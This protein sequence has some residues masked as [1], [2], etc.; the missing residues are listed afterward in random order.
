MGYT[1]GR[2]G[3][4][5][6]GNCVVLVGSLTFTVHGGITDRGYCVTCGEMILEPPVAIAMAKWR[7]EIEGEPPWI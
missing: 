1:V 2:T 5:E 4:P 7:R 3:K 6:L